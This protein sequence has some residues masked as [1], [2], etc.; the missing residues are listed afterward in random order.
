M[1]RKKA[2]PITKGL[3]VGGERLSVESVRKKKLGHLD[4]E[5]KP[6]TDEER[7]IFFN[8]WLDGMALIPL[9]R[10]LGRS[11]KAIYTVEWKILMGYDTHKDYQPKKRKDRTGL[12]WR[13]KGLPREEDLVSLAI[14][15]KVDPK[16]LATILCRSEAE[17]LAKMEEMEKNRI[18]AKGLLK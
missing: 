12:E 4:R 13:V 11:F 15:N 17:V 9:C 3:D 10:K 1:P 5:G 18:H 6:W 2:E 7:D 14:Q 16:W 8:C